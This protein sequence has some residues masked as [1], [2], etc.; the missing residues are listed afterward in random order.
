[1]C[2]GN[3]ERRRQRLRRRARTLLETCGS[4]VSSSISAKFALILLIMCGS[5]SIFSCCIYLLQEK[6]LI[7]HLNDQILVEPDVCS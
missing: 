7:I 2:L 3:G 5:A 1:M 4:I 6:I